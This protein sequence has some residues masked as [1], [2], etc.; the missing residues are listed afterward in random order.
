DRTGPGAEIL[1]REVAQPYLTQV[2]IDIA[3]VKHPSILGIITDRAPTRMVAVLFP[4]LGVAPGGL[5]MAIGPWGDPHIGPG[6]RNVQRFDAGEMRR[7]GERPAIR[8]DVVEAAGAGSPEYTGLG[9]SHIMKP[10][11]A[12]LFRHLLLL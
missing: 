1:G 8:Q 12:S 2:V 10:G 9:V 4:S 7:I 11:E 3:K 5:Q 6:G